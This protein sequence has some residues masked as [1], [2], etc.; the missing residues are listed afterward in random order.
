MKCSRS[1]A[2]S[3]SGLRP[4]KIPDHAVVVED[5]H[6]VM[7]EDHRQEIAV[8]AGAAAARV[9]DARGRGRAV[10]A[11]GDIDR[12]QRIEGA[13][14]RPDGRLV[15]DHPH[16]V[17]HAVVGGDVHVGGVEGGVGQHGVDRRRVR[18]GD[19]HRPGLGV[20]RLDLADAV[21]LLDR[22]GQF[23]PADAVGLVVGD[24]GDRGEPGLHPVAPGQA[25]DVIEAASRRASARRP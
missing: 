8:R 25:V 24:R 2:R 6:L 10:M 11:V 19:H 15:V 1:A 20:D 16:L 17:A 5:R 23:V 4:F 18:I 12:R 21:V 14:Q 3:C 13:R 22:R 9:G 7:R